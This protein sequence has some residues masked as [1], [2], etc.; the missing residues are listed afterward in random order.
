[1]VDHAIGKVVAI[2][3]WEYAG[4][5]P[6]HWEICMMSNWEEQSVSLGWRGWISRIFPRDE[7]TYAQELEA[8]ASLLK[9]L[10]NAAQKLPY[11]RRRLPPSARPP[12]AATMAPIELSHEPPPFNPAAYIGK[13]KNI[14]P[15]SDV[16][17][18]F[19]PNPE[20]N[21][22]LAD[23]LKLPSS[24]A[25]LFPTYFL[26]VCGTKRMAVPWHSHQ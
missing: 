1:M 16:L 23:V 15:S 10:L 17:P 6:A 3:D 4:W 9:A 14:P 8:D 7:L 25:A 24:Q 5:F 2:I 26:P 18:E 12:S 22:A 11:A 20:A 13:N 19:V 21:A